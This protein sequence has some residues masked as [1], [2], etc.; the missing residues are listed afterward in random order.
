[1]NR[2]KILMVSKSI[3]GRDLKLRRLAKIFKI[4]K[5]KIYL[6]DLNLLIGK[7]IIILNSLS[8]MD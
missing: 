3:K 5:V 6:R 1:M 7:Q 2:K 4:Q 8:L